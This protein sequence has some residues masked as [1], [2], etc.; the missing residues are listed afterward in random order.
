MHDK[1]KPAK[2]E[3][4]SQSLDAAEE[5]HNEAT[6]DNEENIQSEIKV[7]NGESNVETVATEYTVT[8]TGRQIA[9]TKGRESK[10]KKANKSVKNDRNEW[11]C[12]I[13]KL[14]E[15]N[16]DSDLILCD[17]PCMRSYHIA[18]LNFDEAETEKVRPVHDL[19]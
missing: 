9:V 15:N 14:Y 4:S 7:S 17:G 6:I 11:I 19:L 18:C 8:R 5:S 2:P 13:C 1:K 3:K 16:D 12:G 10:G